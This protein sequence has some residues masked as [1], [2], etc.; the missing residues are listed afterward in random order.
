MYCSDCFSQM[1]RLICTYIHL[2]YSDKENLDRARKKME[3]VAR[4]VNEG[5]RRAEVVKEVLSS[6]KKPFFSAVKIK[7]LRLGTSSQ[8][9]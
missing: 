1:T 2:I 9:L 3:E 4:N 6:K 8:W 5:R 7:T